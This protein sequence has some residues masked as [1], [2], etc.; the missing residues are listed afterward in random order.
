MTTSAS[1]YH[2]IKDAAR[3]LMLAGDV[4]RY[5][6]ALRLMNGLRSTGAAA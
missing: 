4:E 2:K 5:L 1:R 3:R 6:H